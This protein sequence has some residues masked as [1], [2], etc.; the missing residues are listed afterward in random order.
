MTPSRNLPIIMAALFLLA[1]PLGTLS[2]IGIAVPHWLDSLWW[3]LLLAVVLL[4]ALDALRLQ[5]RTS[6]QLLRRLPDRLLAGRWNTVEL[7]IHPS[8][9]KPL[10]VAIF[11][12]VPD[13]MTSENLPAALFLLP[14]KT[15]RFSYRLRP[16]RRGHFH[17]HYCEIHLPSPWKLW[18]Q[19]RLLSLPEEVHVYP[20]FIR[21]YNAQLTAT[22]LANRQGRQRQPHSGTGQEFHQLREFREGDTLRQIDWKATA[23]RRTFI[24]REYQAEAEQRILFLLDCG[25]RMRSRD[26]ELAHFDHALEACLLLAHIALRQGDAVGLATFSTPQQ[27]YLAPAKG[28]AQMNALLNALYD[29]EST[30]QP[31]DF[32]AAVGELLDR[33]QQRSLVVILSNLRDEDNDELPVALAPL[34][35]RH[36]VVLVSLRETVLDRLRRRPVASFEDTLAYQGA[37]TYLDARE[38]LHRQLMTQGIALLDTSPDE[39]APRLVEHYLARKASGAC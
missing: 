23:R 3:S 9:A 30:R 14:G 19:R 28:Q 26:G 4:A 20:D 12:H 25:N 8:A 24:S 32:T 38:N 27:R 36:A 16:L 7:E 11:D 1:L 35:R 22:P 21:L 2:A 34:L 39:L 15:T 5:H 13:S 31:A 10:T 33:G 37:M 17:F 29:L 18:Q 6:P